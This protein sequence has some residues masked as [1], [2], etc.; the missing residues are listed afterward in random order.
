MSVPATG[1]ALLWFPA[2]A[3]RHVRL[4]M[5]GQTV[6]ML[7][8][9]VIDI[10]LSLLA[11]QLTKS[12]ALL[13]LLNFLLYV[14]GI[15]VTPLFS[16]RLTAANARRRTLSA[17]AAMLCM[18]LVLTGLM[19]LNWLT[20]P[21]IL[22]LAFARGILSG[23]ELPSR[24]MLLTCSIA[25]PSRMA[26][27]VALN[28]VAF[29][30]AR[31]CGPAI[32]GALFGT[33]GPL[34]AFA[35]AS[36]ALVVMLGCVWHLPIDPTSAV[37]ADSH[38]RGGVAGAIDFVRGDTF[39]RLFLPV[40]IC[41]ALF[42]GASQTLVPVLADRVFGDTA[43]WTAVFFAAIGTGGLTAAL[44]LSTRHMPWALGRFQVAL[45]WLIALALIGL[46]LS[47][48]LPLVL[49]CFATL[50]FGMAFVSTCTNAVMLQRV[51]AE[52]RGGLIA[53]FLMSFIGAIPI[54]QLLAGLLAQWLSVQVACLVL[55]AV[56]LTGLLLLFVPRWWGLGR[57]ELDGQRI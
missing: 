1:T 12:P 42:A 33:V 4:Y 14:P 25:E 51:P 53:L 56:L 47:R 5:F 18:A 55:A 16:S 30:A 39:S 38:G 17:L 49:L 32:A 50:G 26:S 52:A 31:M 40:T 34:W 19:A 24:Q 20:V 7:G 57:L 43:R 54:S 45:P 46:G 35:F 23:M 13:G 9:W 8:T 15:V 29:H 6:S 3:E 2:L 21:V 27:A 44:L 36:V 11:W 28:T 48:Q 10:T 41:I 22:V 37:N